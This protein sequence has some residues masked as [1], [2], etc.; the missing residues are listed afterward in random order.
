MALELDT[1]V[2]IETN[3]TKFRGSFKH[4]VVNW[5]LVDGRVVIEP[6]WIID[7]KPGHGF[8][9]MVMEGRGW[10]V[11]DDSVKKVQM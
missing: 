1:A 2:K 11:G 5:K 9:Y 7:R 3:T 6:T 4:R 8:I 10:K